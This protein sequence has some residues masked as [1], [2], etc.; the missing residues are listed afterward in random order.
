MCENVIVWVL[1][2]VSMY[3]CIQICVF[4]RVH[5]CLSGSGYVGFCFCE[6]VCVCVCACAALTMI[7]VFTGVICT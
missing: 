4:A 6:N 2:S 1:L 3:I 7:L 5:V